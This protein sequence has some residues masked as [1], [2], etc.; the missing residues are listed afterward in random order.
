MKHRV[1]VYGLLQRGQG[2]IS[3]DH[4]PGARFISVTRT[5]HDNYTMRDLGSFPAVSSGGMDFIQGELW[6]VDERTLE[7]MDEVEGHPDFYQRETVNTR[8][9]P[10]WMYQINDGSIHDYPVV[11]PPLSQPASWITHSKEQHDTTSEFE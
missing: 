10:A 9:G 2:A 7:F 4:Q 6:E 3:L 11:Q 1:F 5:D 8:H